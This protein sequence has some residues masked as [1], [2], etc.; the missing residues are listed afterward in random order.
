MIHTLLSGVPGFIATL[1]LLVFCEVL[2]SSDVIPSYQFLRMLLSV[3]RTQ[4]R[5]ANVSYR[6]GGQTAVSTQFFECNHFLGLSAGIKFSVVSD[7]P[8]VQI[9]FLVD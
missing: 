6:A 3:T 8:I 9:T 7:S 2:F 4:N 5:V 1:F